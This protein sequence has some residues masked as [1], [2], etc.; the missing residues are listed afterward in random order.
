[1]KPT[2]FPRVHI[3]IGILAATLSIVM[4]SLFLYD[5]I[6]GNEIINPYLAT[7]IFI[8]GVKFTVM[9]ILFYKDFKKGQK[10]PWTKSSP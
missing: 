6:T 7:L 4:A 1:M 3:L 5:R 2:K 9:P 8:A 10:A